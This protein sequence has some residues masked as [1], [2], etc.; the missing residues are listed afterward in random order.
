M[1]KLAR[2]PAEGITEAASAR[3]TPAP[4]PLYVSHK[5]I[6]PKAVRGRYRRIK[7]AVLVV[8]LAVYYVLPWIRWDRGPGAPDQAV[9]LDLASQRFY[10]FAV[11]LWP[12]QIYYLTGALILG[13]VGLFLATALAGRVWC[14]YACPQTVWTDLFIL[15]EQWVE[16]DRGARIRLDNGPRNAAWFLKKTV[17]HAAWLLIGLVTGGVAIFY[18]ADAPTL[19]GE[20]LRFDAPAVAVGWILFFTGCTYAMAGFMREQMCVYVCPWPRFQAAML[21]EESLVVTYQD[22]RGEGRAPVRKDQSWE[23][24]KAEG[25]GDCIDCKACVHVC[26]TG[27]DIRDGIQMDCI[28]CGLCIDAC[29]DVMA[30]IGRPGDLIRYDTQ[31]AQAA[32]AASRTPAPYRLVRPRTIVYTLI[33]LTVAGMIA[34]GLM[35]KPA[36]GV[37]VLRDRAPLFVILADGRVQNSY[38]VKISNMT[39]QPQTYRLAVS[40]IEGATVAVAGADGPDGLELTAQPDAVETYRIHVRARTQALAVPSIKLAFALTRAPD[41]AVL[42]AG[43]VFLAPPTRGEQP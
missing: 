15:V 17:K 31:A 28:S 16:G 9:L 2:P 19:A 5:T 43:T 25:L 22:W 7:W 4:P 33:L 20:L 38:T 29:N 6:H 8:L 12:Q 32:K 40:G 37:T 11:E 14:G 27:I 3:P 18:F 39:R 23:A 21:D 13:A 35:L 34:A 30:R 26:P 10:L 36:A 24:R 41:G 42:E 1:Q